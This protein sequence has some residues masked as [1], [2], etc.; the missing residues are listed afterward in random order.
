M[1]YFKKD[2]CIPILSIS[3]MKKDYL[4]LYISFPRIINFGGFKWEMNINYWGYLQAPFFMSSGELH[5]IFL[6]SLYEIQ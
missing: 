3:K 6:K 1:G 4:I 2:G 5:G